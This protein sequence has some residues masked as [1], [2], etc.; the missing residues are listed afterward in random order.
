MSYKVAMNLPDNYVLLNMMSTYAG[1]KV[2]TFA[3]CGQLSPDGKSL[4]MV[5]KQGTI[6]KI[7]KSTAWVAGII[8]NAFLGEALAFVKV[9]PNG[10]FAQFK[11]KLIKPLQNAQGPGV[12]AETAA[13]R[14]FKQQCLKWESVRSMRNDT[15][16]STLPVSESD[17]EDVSRVAPKSKSAAIAPKNTPKAKQKTLTKAL[18]KKSSSTTTTDPIGT[19]RQAKATKKPLPDDS[20]ALTP[21]SSDEDEV[22]AAEDL[23][24]KSKTRKRKQLEYKLRKARQ[25]SALTSSS[26]D[27]DEVEAAEDLSPKSKT[28]KRKQL[29][30][31]LRKARQQGA[32]MDVGSASSS[33]PID[34]SM[35][36]AAAPVSTSLLSILDK[37][38]ES[39][40]ESAM[41][42]LTG[43]LLEATALQNR[44]VV[45][46]GP[47]SHLP[48]SEL[49]PESKKA[50][51]PVPGSE[52][53]AAVPV[54]HNNYT[55]HCYGTNLPSKAI[56]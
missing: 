21:S 7:G 22:E 11:V 23:S 45:Q 50:K 44:G 15:V 16:F 17:D 30:Y 36:A 28:R 31:K 54:V 10:N 41:E 4:G 52:F 33:A 39:K 42:A 14:L 1:P 49:G 53:A 13:K 18:P 9:L 40:I 51:R 38:L 46:S 32:E 48:P 24:P 26:S 43:K 34:L 37:M 25:H 47:H 20:S 6:V 55:Y 2:S 8:F 56:P 29:E 3:A 19:K 12:H 35:D 27:E 5:S